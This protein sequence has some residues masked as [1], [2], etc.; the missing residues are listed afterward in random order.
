[1]SEE[2]VRPAIVVVSRSA[3]VREQI[4]GELQARYTRDYELGAFEDAESALAGVESPVALVLAGYGGEDPDGLDVL[5]R[6]AARW[7]GALRVPI[8]RWGDWRTTTPIF[9]ALALGQVDRW[10]YR[11]ETAPDEYLHEAVT[12]FLREWRARQGGG[13]E[14]VR[15]VG[16]QWSPRSQQLRDLFTRNWIPLG[17]YDAASPAGKALLHRLGLTDPQLPVVQL[18]FAENSPA[19]ENPSDLDIALAFGIMEPIAADEVFDVVVVGAGPSGLGAAVYAASEGLRTLVLEPDAAGGQAGTSSLIRNY[20]GFPTGISGRQLTFGAFQQAWV[21]GARFHFM[22]AATSLAVDGD[23]RRVGL[24]DGTTVTGRTVVVSTGS[25]YQRL[26]VPA[27]EALQGRGVFYGAAVAEARAM[28]G[29]NVYV[30]GGGNSAGQAAVHL[31]RYADHVTILVRR[32]DLT[33]TMSEYLIKEIDALPNVDVRGRVQVVDGHGG[34][35]LEEFVVE[36]LDTSERFTLHGVLFALIGSRPRSDWLDG[37]VTRDRWG[38]VVTG[39]DAAGESWPLDRPPLFL[40]TSVP[41]VFAVGDVREGSVKR[42]AS[43]VGE[44]ALA[45]TLVHQYLASLAHPAHD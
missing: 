24:T 7:P 38:S 34:E 26:G 27:L 36:D 10:T 28:R 14:A 31:S 1:M 20:L 42:V 45:V 32:P 23:L 33:E 2:N 17:F 30:V 19:L 29:R 11:P 6:L 18:R 44:G 25:S 40:E 8:V 43:A 13:F 15:I 37:V 3:D 12:E 35:F 9:E 21:F 16:E 22:R 39:A 5:A 4:C 41:G